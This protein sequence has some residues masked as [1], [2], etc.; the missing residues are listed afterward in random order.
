MFFMRWM[1]KENISFSFLINHNQS[2]QHN[3]YEGTL[4]GWSILAKPMVAR[5]AGEVGKAKSSEK[6]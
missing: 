4:I 3:K 5:R 2:C 1:F 6:I